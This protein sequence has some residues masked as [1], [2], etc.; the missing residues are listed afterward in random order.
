MSLAQSALLSLQR[1]GES[2]YAARQAFA[3]EVQMNASH[4]VGIV[5]SEPFSSEA[6]RAYARLRSI[7]RMAHD[8]QSMEEQLKTLYGSAI[9]LGSP[10]VPV[11][12]ALSNQRER[13]PASSNAADG[14][15]A[16][17]TVMKPASQKK[18]MKAKGAQKAASDPASQTPRL[19]GN[20]EAVLAYL[21]QVLDR[22]S[23]KTLTQATIAEG[24]GIPL[25]SVGLAVR[26]VVAAGLVREGQKGSYRLG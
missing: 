15:G 25:G 23:W 11:L 7:A 13:S 17:D 26:R 16:Q 10:D 18:P 12:V 19:S 6:D 1:A 2:L 24:A 4:V 14:E 9:N 22:R 21:T 8:L 3:H 20:D 5:A